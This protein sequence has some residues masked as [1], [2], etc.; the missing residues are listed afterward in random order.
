VLQNFG[1]AA[2]LLLQG[3]VFAQISHYIA[4]YKKDILA[5][6]AF[7]WGLLFLTTLKTAQ[8]LSVHLRP[9]AFISL[10]TFLGCRTIMWTQNVVNF[11][12]IGAATAMFYTLWASKATLI[13]VG[14]IAFYV[15]LFFC[16]RLWVTLSP[17][18]RSNC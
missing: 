8:I 18:P 7:V 12:D 2:D 16:Q 10:T 14:L 1:I 3:I 9:C 6:R 11:T 13:L 17:P 15:Q 5:L 4:L